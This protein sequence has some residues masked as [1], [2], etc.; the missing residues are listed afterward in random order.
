MIFNSK[1]D[2]LDFLKNSNSIFFSKPTITPCH[3]LLLS[4]IQSR[5][6]SDIV[7]AA[8]AA[9]AYLHI[10]WSTLYT[11]IPP[12]FPNNNIIKRM[13]AFRGSSLSSIMDR[14]PFST[15]S[16]GICGH[17]LATDDLSWESLLL[18]ENEEESD[19]KK[20]LHFHRTTSGWYTKTQNFLPR[21]SYYLRSYLKVYTGIK[22]K[23]YL[24]KFLEVTEKK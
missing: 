22:K 18:I 21:K 20:K 6:I 14:S 9:A 2:Y 17:L 8:A 24:K 5:Y 1:S 13:A 19:L 15:K 11:N 16:I 7:P 10:C 23:N 4:Q 3:H 12:S